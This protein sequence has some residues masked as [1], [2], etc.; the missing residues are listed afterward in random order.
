MN[1]EEDQEPISRK[2]W[3]YFVLIALGIFVLNHLYWMDLGHFYPIVVWGAPLF[4]MVGLSG[5]VYP[6]QVEKPWVVFA[7]AATGLALGI[8]AHWKLY[9]F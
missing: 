4:G 2:Q 5:M 8:F 1:T 7:S 3:L 6:D 9:G